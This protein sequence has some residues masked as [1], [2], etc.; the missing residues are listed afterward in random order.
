L[1][2]SRSTYPVAGLANTLQAYDKRTSPQPVTQQAAEQKA[3][4]KNTGKEFALARPES[5]HNASNNARL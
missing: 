1:S 5:N 4:A 3:D 2:N